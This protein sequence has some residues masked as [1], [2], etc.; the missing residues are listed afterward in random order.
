MPILKIENLKVYYFSI[1]G[2]FKAVDEINLEVKEGES[3][4]LVGESGCGK[5]TVALAILDLVPSPG[6]KVDSKIFFR[7]ENLEEKS[8]KEKREIRG[9]EIGIVFQD[10]SLY[11]NP[12]LRIGDQISEVLILHKGLS[13]KEAMAKSIEILSMLEIPSPEEVIKYYPHQLSGGMKQRVIIGIAIARNPYL[14]IADEPTTALDV[15]V[16]FQILE[17]L[18]NLKKQ[19]NLSLLFISH[20]LG[21]VTNICD[22]V[23]VMYAGKI[24]ES[25]KIE[26]I[27]NSPLHPYTK[28]LLDCAVSVYRKE[29][30][31][32]FITGEVP[33]VSKSLI[34]C[35]FAPRCNSV[36]E[37][38]L[39]E[40]PPIFEKKDHSVYCWLY[41]GEDELSRD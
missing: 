13:K 35:P 37:I 6:K 26:D 23:Y 4:G 28:R 17:L 22:R 30:N 33:D 25:A 7:G 15:S 34:G 41:G 3:V 2:V 10:P 1:K 18:K 27:Y 8:N 16:Q 31:L 20:D 40:F 5:S 39:K 29:K 19:M 32:D 14:L 24:C 12:V 11:L 38:C 9:K 21:L 36:K